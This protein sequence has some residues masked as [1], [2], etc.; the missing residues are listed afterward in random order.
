MK[1]KNLNDVLTLKQIINS[2][3]SKLFHIHFIILLSKILFPS[4]PLTTLFFLFLFLMS[5][6][7]EMSPFQRNL[8]VLTSG[9]LA[10]AISRTMT[11]PIERIKVLLQTNNKHYTDKSLF[12]CLLY[13][14]KNEGVTGLFQGNRVNVIRVV[15]FSALEFFTFDYIRHRILMGS[16]L[17]MEK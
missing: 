16:P 10:G 9:A 8:R 12:R 17:T 5:S 11:A 13:M 14:Y 6:S 4:F 2:K 15:P 3:S 7:L 1:K